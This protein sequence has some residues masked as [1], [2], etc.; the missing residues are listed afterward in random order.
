M[1]GVRGDDPIMTTRA[2]AAAA[3]GSWAPGG[4]SPQALSGTINVGG[5]TIPV[6]ATSTS[7][8]ATVEQI[9]LDLGGVTVNVAQP[10]VTVAGSTLAH[11]GGTYQ[12]TAAQVDVRASAPNNTATGNAISIQAAA[13]NVNVDDRAATTNHTT[14][15]YVGSNADLTMLDA[16]PV[17][18]RTRLAWAHDWISN[19]ALDATFQSLPGS[20]FIVNG[21]APPKNS[22]LTT[23]AAELH[24]TANWSLTGKFDGEFASRSQT[25]AGTGT[26]RYTW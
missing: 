26:L 5:A 10:R 11:I 2:Q 17:I 13:A 25:Y 23:A 8:A 22:A 6:H 14:E 9:D 18:L 15:A 3:F 16:M 20:S 21:A 1:T 24:M 7:N 4:Q 19:P 12:I